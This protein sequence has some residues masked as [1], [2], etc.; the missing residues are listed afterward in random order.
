MTACSQDRNVLAT[1]LDGE[2]SAEQERSLQE[3]L[4]NC[5][6][7]VAE[8]AAQ[9]RLRRAMKPAAMRFAPS[10]EFRSKVHLQVTP[11]R[12]PGLRWLWPAAVAALALMIVA[13]V[14]TRQST[15][16]NQAFREVADLHV[17]DLAS[18]NPYDV[19]SSDRHTVKPWFQ[20]RIPFAF[21]VPE[22][23]GSEFT[24]LGGRLV[25]MHQQPAAQLV[26]GTGRHKIS[27]LILQE[28]SEVGSRLPFSGG[29][30]VRDSFNV[31]TWGT[32]GIRFY[33]IGDAEQGAIHRLAQALQTVNR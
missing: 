12:R 1:Y 21:N 20:G 3:H 29:V 17:S 11:K 23:S 5:P 24:L 2:L 18:A 33:V 10:A 4:R 13:L 30:A 26:V 7:C 25:Y 19:V 27:V 8:I 15:L 9:V 22:F 32:N 28:S 16:R 31:E 6:E 14:W